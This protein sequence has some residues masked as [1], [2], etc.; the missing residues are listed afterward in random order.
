MLRGVGVPESTLGTYARTLAAGGVLIA[1]T[2]P[3]AG[4]A[5]AEEMLADHQVIGA[6][7]TATNPAS[8]GKRPPAG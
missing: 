7:T 8:V 1:L 4:S 2:V 6:T 5:V 3:A